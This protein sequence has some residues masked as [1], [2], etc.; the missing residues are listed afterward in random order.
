MARIGGKADKQ[1]GTAHP[2]THELSKVPLMP[3]GGLRCPRI[4]HMRVV[5]PHD[6]PSVAASALPVCSQ[7]QQRLCHVRIAQIPRIDAVPE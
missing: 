3:A 7:T 6:D 5:R 1:C 2:L 4:A